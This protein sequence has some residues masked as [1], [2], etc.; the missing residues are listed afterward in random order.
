MTVQVNPC[1]CRSAV[2]CQWEREFPKIL[3]RRGLRCDSRLYFL[4]CSSDK[5]CLLEKSEIFFF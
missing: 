2:Q 5:K 4:E 3:R 1:G